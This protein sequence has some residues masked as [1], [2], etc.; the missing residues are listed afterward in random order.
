MSVYNI[1]SLCGEQDARQIKVETI[2]ILSYC[3][4]CL[5]NICDELIYEPPKFFFIV[6]PRRKN[7]GYSREIF[8]TIDEFEEWCETNEEIVDSLVYGVYK[9][10]QWSQNDRN[11]WI[12]KGNE[13]DKFYWHPDEE[14][15]D[16]D[17]DT[18][19]EEE[20][21]EEADE[22]DRD[23]DDEDDECIK[24]NR[25]NSHIRKH[26]SLQWERLIEYYKEGDDGAE[27]DIIWD[28]W[29]TKGVKYIPKKTFISSQ[30]DIIQKQ[31]DKLNNCID[32][33]VSL[34][35]GGGKI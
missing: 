11:K 34:Q 14:D 18:N 32:H 26:I 6:K 23:A 17:L 21:E 15:S 13:N 28:I 33:F 10:L 27:E 1:C 20:E 30:I 22:D 24:K 12:T 31:I 2:G 7:S 29:T 9:S 4:S 3:D 19:N 5:D 8:A 35:K 16:S 25:K